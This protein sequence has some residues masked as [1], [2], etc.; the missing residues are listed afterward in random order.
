MKKQLFTTL[1]TFL[2]SFAASAYVPPY[3]MIMS[4]TAEQ[5]GKGIYAVDQDVIF[6]SATGETLVV[7][8]RWTIAGENQMRLDVSGRKQLKDLVR[9]TFIYDD[10]KRYFIDENG[11]K[12]SNRVAPDFFEPLFHFRFS[13]NIKPYLVAHKIAPSESLRSESHKYSA[14]R[15]RAENESYVR[16]ARSGGVVTYAIGAASPAGSAELSPGIWIDQD[17]FVVRKIRFPTQTVVTAKDYRSYAQ[18]LMLPKEREISF[19]NYTVQI[20]VNGVS[21]LAASAP[22]KARLATNSLNFGENPALSTIIPAEQVIR[23]FYSRLR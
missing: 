22:T 16:L 21:S 2:L 12:K 6:Q 3:W 14:K 9:L 19:N 15:P 20:S 1:C 23:D 4:K 13:K 10:G 17:Q 18:G 8:E 11:V 5:H 7:N